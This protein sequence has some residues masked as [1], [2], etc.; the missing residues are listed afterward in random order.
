MR[1]NKYILNCLP[2]VCLF[3]LKDCEADTKSEESKDRTEAAMMT[4]LRNWLNE[5][6]TGPLPKYCSGPSEDQIEIEQYL[7]RPAPC[8]KK[9]AIRR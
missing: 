7:V 5:V 1:P 6:I 4:E 8:H 9:E 2:L 3:L